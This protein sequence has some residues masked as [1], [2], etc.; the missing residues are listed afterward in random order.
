MVNDTI[1]LYI[2]KPYW[3]LR[4]HIVLL[5][6]GVPILYYINNIR[7]TYAHTWAHRLTLLW[8]RN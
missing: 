2:S 5:L 1:L 8:Y 7:N 3:W 6:V 4:S